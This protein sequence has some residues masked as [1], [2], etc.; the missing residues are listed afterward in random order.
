M[1]KILCIGP[2]WRGSNAGGL[3]KALSTN[4][5]IIDV[6]DEFYHISLSASSF[7]LKAASKIIRPYQIKEFNSAICERIKGFRPDV[8][9]VYKGAFVLPE[10]L[11][12]AKSKSV[13]IVNFYPDVS[14][15]S[16]GSLLPKAMPKYDLVFTTKT[17]GINDLKEK[18]GV[19]NAKFIPHGFDP[20]IHKKINIPADEVNDF[21]CDVS[22]IGTWSAKKEALLKKVK[23]SLPNV[24]L[25]IWGAQWEKAGEALNGAI[26]NM[27]VYGDLY[28]YAINA[29]KINLGILSEQVHGASSGDLITSRTFHITGAGGF[30]LHE[31][32]EE[33]IQYYRENEECAFFDS[34]DDLVEKIR[35]YLGN[36]EQRN[37]V[38]EQGY[39]RAHKE[40]SLIKRAAEILNYISNEL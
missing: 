23:Q 4:G 20:D 3:F 30:L 18:M 35:Y 11:D 6:I 9:L 25:K 24:N 16:H 32:N 17:F 29:S 31:K 7:A 37:I 14:M 21:I 26:T 19:N 22:F 34:G 12:Y 8:L 13:S 27:V 33:S 10:T 36:E 1:K 39:I 2:L 40:Y 28:S 15:Y 38:K 5:A